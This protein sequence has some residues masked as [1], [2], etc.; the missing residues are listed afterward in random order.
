M[1]R[2][3]NGLP[4]VKVTKSTITV[5][6]KS[7]ICGDQMTV[8]LNVDNYDKIVDIGI[9][10]NGCCVISQ[11]SAHHMVEYFKGKHVGTLLDVGLIKD[12]S[13]DV[14]SRIGCLAFPV[15]ILYEAAKAASKTRA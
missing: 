13:P 3:K 5:K 2:W 1:D 11:G 10:A 6:R 4:K 9:I 15:G 14:R 7:T 8:N 12:V